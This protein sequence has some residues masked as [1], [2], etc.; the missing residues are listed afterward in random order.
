[1]LPTAAGL[2][3]RGCP[4][5]L[6]Q[7]ARFVCTTRLEDLPPAVVD[8]AKRLIADC[9]A[10]VTAGN[11]SDELK[12]LARSVGAVPAG[13]PSWVI[14]TPHSA[15]PRDAAFLNGIASTWH[16]FDEGSTIAYCHPA[17]QSIPAALALA[18]A[19]QSSG[20]DLLL[21]V[22]LGYEVSARVGRASQMRVSV[23]PH[24]TC[25][26]IGSAVA[27]A[28]LNGFDEA[29]VRQVI[30]IA[31]TMAMATNRQAML[32]EATVRNLYTGH[33][34]LAGQIAV[35]LAQ[36][37]FT[38]Q[39][40]GIGFTFG[41]VI[42]D[43]FDPAIALK[44]LG[45]DWLI[46]RGYFK[47][48]PAGRYAHAAIDALEDA[49]ATLPGTIKAEDVARID[50]RAFRL[51]ALLSGK[52]VSTSF[53]AK[54]SIPFALATLI[55]HGR[56]NLEAFDDAAV[57]NPVIQ[58]LASRVEVSE[59]PEYTAL[60]PDQHRCDLVLTM[61]DG[62]QAQG[63]CN[64]MKGDPANPHRPEDVEQKFFD[65]TAPIWGDAHAQSIY[66]A[67]LTLDSAAS[68]ARLTRALAAPA[69]SCA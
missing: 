36:A 59:V 17:S 35:Q 43:G 40:D 68:L 29:G 9:I 58:A 8:R 41:T 14:G 3:P 19:L 30:N 50:V 5:Y 33:T 22:V 42:A 57:A 26:T 31:A 13:G 1:M 16:D 61:N 2:D 51:A 27:A 69:I 46:T 24:G 45:S 28:R 67:C 37:G 62:R 38:G 32:D 49:L 65:L 48:H 39:R 11:Q 10:I 53:G 6:E 60:Y 15:S 20:R 63:R 34:A 54:F 12:A 56:S 66:Q 21:A 64:M 55:H 4:A 25:G 23:H 52:H 18:Q 7:I 47:L 44:D